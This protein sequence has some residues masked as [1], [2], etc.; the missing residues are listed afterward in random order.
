MRGVIPSPS[1]V[2]AKAA[3]PL[4]QKCDSA[5]AHK[6]CPEKKL[7]GIIGQAEATYYIVQFPYQLHY[8]NATQYITRFCNSIPTLLK[9]D[10][11]IGTVPTHYKDRIHFFPT[12]IRYLCSIL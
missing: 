9:L 10:M 2:A 7:T 11:M 12:D 5:V 1:V 4:Q 3:R 6:F 8:N